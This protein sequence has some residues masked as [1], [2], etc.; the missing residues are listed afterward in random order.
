VF[1]LHNPVVGTLSTLAETI[2]I[3]PKFEDGK[4]TAEDA[5]TRTVYHSEKKA[6][7]SEKSA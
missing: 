4:I 3:V 2:L 1:Y 5:V 6:R 7:S